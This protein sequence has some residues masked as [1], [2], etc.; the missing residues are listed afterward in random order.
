ML[1]KHAKGTAQAPPELVPNLL[2]LFCNNSM[3]GQASQLIALVGKE[4]VGALVRE[5][6]EMAYIEALLKQASAASP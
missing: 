3:Y 2:F 5:E 1:A 6:K 4:Q